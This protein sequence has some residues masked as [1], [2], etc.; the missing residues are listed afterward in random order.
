MVED[1]ALYHLFL[2]GGL[3]N[4]DYVITLTYTM[5]KNNGIYANT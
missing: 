1:N 5:D 2:N 4:T 3:R